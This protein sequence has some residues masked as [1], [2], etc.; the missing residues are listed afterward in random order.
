MYYAY[1]QEGKRVQFVHALDHYEAIKRGFL[2]HP[3]GTPEPPAPPAPTLKGEQAAGIEPL[4]PAA[5]AGTQDPAAAAK[6]AENL[7]KPPVA[8]KKG[9]KAT[10]AAPSPVEGQDAPVRRKRA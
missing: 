5:A 8:E 9:K 6:Q 3:P 7:T 1:T 2:R 4:A 10:K